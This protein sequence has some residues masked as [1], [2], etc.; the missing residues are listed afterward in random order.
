MDDKRLMRLR[1]ILAGR[2]RIYSP[3]IICSSTARSVLSD[4]ESHVASR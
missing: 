3:C 4:C 1:L 2:T